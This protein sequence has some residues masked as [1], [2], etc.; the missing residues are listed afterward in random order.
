MVHAGSD[1]EKN[2]S[3]FWELSQSC[4]SLWWQ[5][6]SIVRQTKGATRN[7]YLSGIQQLSRLSTSCQD[8]DDKWTR[9]IPIPSR[10]VVT[11]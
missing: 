2:R 1:E 8:V 11:N 6:P 9:L 7:L 10:V 5:T 3:S 4:A